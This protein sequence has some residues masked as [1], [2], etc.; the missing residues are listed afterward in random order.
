MKLE[1]LLLSGDKVK[2]ADFGLAINLDERPRSPVGT[3]D[4]NAPE[5]RLTSKLSQLSS[6]S[7]DSNH[8][9]QTQM[10]SLSGGSHEAI[11]KC[12]LSSHKGWGICLQ[13]CHMSLVD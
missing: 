4:Y 10:P 8:A 6:K 13:R 1:N 2:L 9:K 12:R 11:G 7:T 5:V 3:V